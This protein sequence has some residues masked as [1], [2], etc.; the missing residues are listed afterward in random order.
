MT[1]TVY[2]PKPRY[3]V[4]VANSINDYAGRRHQGAWNFAYAY[5]ALTDAEAMA[6]RLAEDNE[7]V[8][9]IDRADNEETA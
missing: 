7:Y 1:T 5:D 9:V 3:V 4:E 6:D 2:E 8:R